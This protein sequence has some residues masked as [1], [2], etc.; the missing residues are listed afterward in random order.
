MSS[1]RPGKPR[2]EDRAG[3]DIDALYG[4]EPVFEPGAAGGTEAQAYGTQFVS[5]Q[6][7]FCGE[8]CETQLDLSAGVGVAVREYPTDTGPADYLLFIN[9]TACGVI[10]AKKDSIATADPLVAEVTIVDGVARNAISGSRLVSKDLLNR[11]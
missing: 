9:R 5:I 10:E 7:P 8:R 1:R 4:L 2:V 6:C 11:R 3:L